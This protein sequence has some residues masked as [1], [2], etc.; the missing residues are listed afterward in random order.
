M[1]FVRW[2]IPHILASVCLLNDIKFFDDISHT[3]FCLNLMLLRLNF[4]YYRNIF[5]AFN[6]IKINF[7]ETLTFYNRIFGYS[8][9]LLV[10]PHYYMNCYEFQLKVSENANQTDRFSFSLIELLK[11]EK[12]KGLHHFVFHLS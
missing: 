9:S 8:K 1:I 2:G 5:V 4:C 10:R 11:L 7:E 12:L 6:G 3:L